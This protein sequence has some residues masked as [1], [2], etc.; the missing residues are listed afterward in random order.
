MVGLGHMLSSVQSLGFCLDTIGPYESY[1]QVTSGVME[2]YGGQCM[3]V[4][5]T[6]LVTDQGYASY[7]VVTIQ[8]GRLV[9]TCDLFTVLSWG[10][11]GHFP[12]KTLKTSRPYNTFWSF[13]P[14]FTRLKILFTF[15][16]SSQAKLARV[17][18]KVVI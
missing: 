17:F 2:S 7:V 9:T 15:S 10:H 6:V 8:G 3:G 13:I 4:Q 11:F 12:L 14:D 16:K 18:S 5:L 1:G